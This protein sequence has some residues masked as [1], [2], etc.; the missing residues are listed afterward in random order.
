[1]HSVF[2]L[3]QIGGW[4]EGVNVL[5]PWICPCITNLHRILVTSYIVFFEIPSQK[6]CIVL[7][8]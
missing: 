8:L 2:L 5:R 7:K 1:M 6:W 3:Y 4:A